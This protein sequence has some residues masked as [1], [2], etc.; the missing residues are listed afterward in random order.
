MIR[1]TQCR[2]VSDPLEGVAVSKPNILALSAIPFALLI[3]GCNS[4]GSSSSNASTTTTTTKPPF[5][6]PT[7]TV[8]PT[9]PT[10]ISPQTTLP[11]APTTTT[12]AISSTATDWEVVVGIF[13]TSAK[14][15]AQIDKLTAAKFPGFTIKPVTGKYAV[16][17]AGLVNAQAN[18]LA[19][20]INAAKVGSARTLR[21]TGASAS[22]F[23]VVDGIFTT[24][25]IAQAQVDKLTAAKFTGFT[26]KPVT[27]KFAV[28]LAGLTNAQAT[29]MVTQINAAGLGPA[30]VKQLT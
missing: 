14:A 6:L 12:I 25:A 23:E 8:D 10:L 19:F 29:A 22:N 9:P 1:P 27:G 30:R 21:L 5:V 24:S 28:V 13:T 16:V 20:K 3:A 18:A 17:L 15:Q 11:P 26:I 4:S 7:I 2:N